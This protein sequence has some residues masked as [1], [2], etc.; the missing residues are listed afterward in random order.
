V[1]LQNVV[2][3]LL[4]GSVYGLV[5]FGLSLLFGVM[6]IV[7]FAHGAVLMIGMYVVV[8]LTSLF[9]FDPYLSAAIGTPMLFVF[10]YLLGLSVEPILMRERSTGPISVLLWTVGFSL[11]AINIVLILFGADYRVV[12]SFV[13]G[14][15]LE[16]AGVIIS[17]PRL[18]AAVVAVVTFV[19]LYLLLTR[20]DT[21]KA[22]RATSQDMEAARM[23]GI[24]ERKMCRMA[25]AISAATTAVAAGVLVPFYYVSP[26]VGDVFQLKSFVIVVL[27]GIGTISGCLLGGWIV[28][29]VE[30]LGAQYLNATYAQMLVFLVFVVI[31][32]VRPMGLLGKER[33]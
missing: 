19:G 13:S 14:K 27:G 3:G 5:A 17:L 18:G 4:M 24:D 28:G 12:E 6:K 15:T 9:G 25:F 31:L 22:M 29:L 30:S 16:I 7:N 23:L 2:T 21:G 26:T 1:L 33:E 11:F 10:G 32:L 20:T 8:S